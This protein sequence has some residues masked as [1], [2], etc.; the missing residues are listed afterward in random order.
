MHADRHRHRDVREQADACP[1][2]ISHVPKEEAVPARLKLVD[3]F[4]FFVVIDIVFID[5]LLS[6]S[7]L[8]K[9]ISWILS[10][11]AFRILGCFYMSERILRVALHGTRNFPVP[12]QVRGD[13]ACRRLHPL[14]YPF[15]KHH[16]GLP[17]HNQH[18][19]LPPPPPVCF[20]AHRHDQEVRD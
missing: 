9:G 18:H 7:R 8:K 5:A 1:L 16:P 14:H 4:G 19:S 10:F 20:F 2:P 3:V 17:A 12:L 15:R 11:G 13:Q 6:K